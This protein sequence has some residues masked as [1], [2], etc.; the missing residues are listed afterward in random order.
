MAESKN[1]FEEEPD[2]RIKWALHLLSND[3]MET[4]SILGHYFIPVGSVLSTYT[5]QMIRKRALRRPSYVGWPVTLGLM[6]A[7]WF[8]GEDN[9]ASE[10]F[11][12]HL[13]FKS[14]EFLR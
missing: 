10:H 9:L 7:A 8:I 4:T 13:K 11:S 6:T 5:M 3:D 14:L 2:P 12:I 1:I